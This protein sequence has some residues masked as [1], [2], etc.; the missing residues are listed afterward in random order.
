[1]S[2][3]KK[4]VK[5]CSRYKIHIA[6]LLIGIPVISKLDIWSQTMLG[7]VIDQISY[8]NKWL[9]VMGKYAIA[10]T[11]LFVVKQGYS[12]VEQKLVFRVTYRLRYAIAEKVLHVNSRSL[13]SYTTDDIMHMWNQDVEE[14]QT[15]SIT[16][17]LNYGVLF[18][19]ALLA[20]MEL[21]TISLYFPI[22]ALVVNI[23]AVAPLK[24]IGQ[25]TK[26]QSQRQRDSQVAMN[27]KF[28][29]ILNAIRLVK[30][31][32]KEKKEIAE[33]DT[34]NHQYVDDKMAFS[35]STRIYKSVVTAVKSIAPTLIL[36]IANFEIRDGRMTVGDIVLATSLLETIS[37][38][39]S[40]G[41]TFFVNLKGIGF[42]FEHLFQ[43]LEEEGEEILG[44]A[45][46]EAHPY[47]IEL[48]NVSFQKILIRQQIFQ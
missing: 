18:I 13:L 33:F 15:I 36:L 44:E 45:L 39:F 8:T 27:A 9:Y 46:V 21:R 26:K 29:T 38:P 35:I 12:W 16:S 31:Y 23:L 1:M 5:L 2:I 42:K 20:L 3:F 28:Y 40:E 30:S 19:S 17:I 7:S 34:I 10:A 48:K 14:M 32:G 25:K 24:I 11:V 47:E 4:I 41:G 6:V 22:I 37:K 43:F